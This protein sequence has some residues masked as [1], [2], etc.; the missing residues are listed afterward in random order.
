MYITIMGIWRLRYLIKIKFFLD[1]QTYNDF[2][3]VFAFTARVASI[4]NFLLFIFQYLWTFV[5]VLTTHIYSTCRMFIHKIFAI[6][7]NK[8][9]CVYVCVF[10]LKFSSICRFRCVFVYAFDSI[11]L[12]FS[13]ASCKF[14]THTYTHTLLK[15]IEEK[16]L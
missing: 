3:F 5:L 7:F 13:I 10:F 12:Y 6:E 2:C 9:V 14:H 16:H 8:C 11:I 4:S 1:R 15:Q